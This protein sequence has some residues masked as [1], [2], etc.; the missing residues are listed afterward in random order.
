MERTL[1]ILKPDAVKRALVGEVISRFER[2]GLK[3]IGIKMLKPSHQQYYD[4]YESISKMIS[5]RGKEAFDMTL[6]FME[7]G[8]VIA[9]VLEG[10]NG[11]GLVRKMVGDTEPLKAAPG[12]IRGDYAHMG[13]EHSN[14]EK[15]GVPNIVHASGDV[16]EAKQE[17]EHWF[18]KSELFEY[19]TVHSLYT[20]AMHKDH[21]RGAPDA[22]DSHDSNGDGVIRPADDDA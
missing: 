9:A 19:D 18:S 20:Q 10:I 15:I 17:I 6:Q 8:P 13:F 7:E 21:M 4:H 22:S 3:L 14:R 11:V 5:R 12:T 1:I 2:A 16:E